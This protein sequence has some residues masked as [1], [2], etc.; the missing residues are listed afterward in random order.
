MSEL[1][2]N[3]KRRFDLFI[4]LTI[5]A[6]GMAG[7]LAAY[8]VDLLAV[9]IALPVIAALILTYRRYLK[10]IEAAAA[11]AEQAEQH[12]LELSQHI[13]EQERLREQLLR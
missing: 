10:H 5:C 12:V 6:G 1:A 8:R 3:S 9:A 4:W 7:L 11:Q 2:N 13:A